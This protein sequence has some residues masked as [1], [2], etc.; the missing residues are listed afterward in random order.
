MLN[1]YSP[2]SFP[3]K[4]D[5][6]IDWKFHELINPHNIHHS[7]SSKRLRRSDTVDPI[8]SSKQHNQGR[9][10]KAKPCVSL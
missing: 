9:Y 8:S 6:A 5:H 3:V 4:S 7:E 10:I 2:E 1:H